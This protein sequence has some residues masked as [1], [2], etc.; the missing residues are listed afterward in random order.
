M[1]PNRLIV[2]AYLTRGT[3][4]WLATRSIASAVLFLGG[5]DPLRISRGVAVE[6]VLLSVVV[7]VLEMKRRREST[8]LANLGVRWFTIGALCV[9]PALVGELVVRLAGSAI[10]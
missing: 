10:S 3:A 6:I 8:L 5:T 2:R 1:R 9:A 4:L 7:S